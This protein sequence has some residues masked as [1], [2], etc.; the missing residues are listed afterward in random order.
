MPLDPHRLSAIAEAHP[1]IAGKV[2]ALAGEGATRREIA[3]HL[4]RSYQQVRQVLVETERRRGTRSIA[5]TLVGPEA[6]DRSGSGRFR[7]GVGPDGRVRL[8]PDVMDQL[9]IRPGS[10]L[11]GQMVAG[12]LVL[13]GPAEG[14]RRA[15]ELVQ[16]RIPVSIDLSEELLAGRRRDAGE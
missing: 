7:L 16:R 12:E 11:T 8:P 4:G 6:P 14:L 13:T 10:A 5:A 1:T 9:G 15:Q 2:R 3:D